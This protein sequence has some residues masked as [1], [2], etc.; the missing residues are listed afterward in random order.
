[1]STASTAEAFRIS[2][3]N[4]GPVIPAERIPELFQ[5]MIRGA[6]AGME[7]GVGLGLF[8]VREIVDRHH[9]T[10]QVESAPGQGTTFTI[11]IPSASDGAN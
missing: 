9:G 1:V 8:I 11:A 3:H 10:I 2:V 5:P 7:G 6:E 4:D